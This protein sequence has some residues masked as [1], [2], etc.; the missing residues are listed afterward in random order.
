MAD[1]KLAAVIESAGGKKAKVKKVEQAPTGTKAKKLPKEVLEA[2]EQAFPKAK[3]RNVRIHTGGN[4]K[5]VSKQ[6]GA[7]A[8]TIGDD[9]FFGKPGD[10][11]DKK[12][13]AH[14][15]AHVV[16]QGQGKMPKAQPGKALTSK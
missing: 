4:A 8:F 16:Q 5:D 6:L 3:L 12:L 1:D 14:E 15:L 2:V 11:A 13:L 10:A 7:R 9:I